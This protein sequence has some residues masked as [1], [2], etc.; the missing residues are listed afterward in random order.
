M[1]PTH[2]TGRLQQTGI[3]V[4]GVLVFIYVVLRAKLLSVTYDEAWSLETYVGSSFWNIITFEPCD[5]NNHLLNSV[6]I[7][8]L[9]SILPN[10]LF[11]ARIPSV[12][13]CLVF[14]MFSAKLSKLYA[15]NRAFLLFFVLCANPF[16]LD[17][18]S[19]SRGYSIA[20]A[21][22]MASFYY[23]LLYLSTNKTKKALMS[24]ILQAIA[25]LAV[26]SFLNLFA[27]IFILLLGSHLKRKQL[28][29]KNTL[30][31]L[32]PA[33]L[34][35]AILGFP[36]YKLTR[37]GNLYYGGT[38]GVYHDSY[39]SLFRYSTYNMFE[40]AWM[41]YAAA[42]FL[43]LLILSFLFRLSAF[44][45]KLQHTWPLF[46]L[47]ICVV[48]NV[49]QVKITNGFYL[50][51]RTALFYYPLL[52]MLPFATR[53]YHSKLQGLLPIFISVVIAIN[54]ICSVNFNRSL[55]WFFDADTATTLQ[56]LNE[57]GEKYGQVLAIGCSWP[58]HKS[59]E[60]Y[61]R[62]GTYSYL[63]QDWN[64]NYYLY[65]NSSLDRIDYYPE[66]EKILLQEK[67]TVFVS[68]L[69]K[70]IVFKSK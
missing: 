35:L 18:F 15:P 61:L 26:L 59:V 32:L 56:K 51:D 60:Y 55:V 29:T 8:L 53:K 24:L 63:K 27:A 70:V 47:L 22:S 38:N 58:L 30:L 44:E 34:L 43:S 3:L 9:Y 5:S 65:L 13:S 6:L 45:N 46:L 28:F 57:I 39:L 12:L 36:L 50:I 2:T 68:Q 10:T 64:P 16:M 25:A 20:L 19:L 14:L 42:V 11:V 49:A 31:L 21:A 41:P 66:Q 62:N 7:K 1:L 48:I 54:L 17:F 40:S 52:L 69:S 67:D 33:L 37:Y 4:Y 23:L